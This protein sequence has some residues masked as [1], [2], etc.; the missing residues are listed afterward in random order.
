MAEPF[1]ILVVCTGNIC[2]SPMAQALL[3]HRLR[4][5]LGRDVA[6]RDFV[7]LSAGTHGVVG[8]PI[9]AAAMDVLTGWGV[10]PD[11]FE[12][13]ELVAA[14]VEG[15]DLVL[16]ASR[17]HRAAVVTLVPGAYGRTFTVREFARL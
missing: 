10:S 3:T 7:V 8:H 2:R 17:E 14:H 5:R 13:R 9:E 12:A 1:R 16:G 15:A 4:E 6:D 11:P